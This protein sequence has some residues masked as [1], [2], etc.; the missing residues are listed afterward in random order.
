MASPLL[1]PRRSAACV[2]TVT[3]AL[4][5]GLGLTGCGDDDG[6]T[7]RQ[8]ART[9]PDDRDLPRDFPAADFPLVGDVHHAEAMTWGDGDRSVWSINSRADTSPKEA[10]DDAKATLLEAGF[11]VDGSGREHKSADY[12][13]VVMKHG[14]HHVTLSVF[15]G[16]V[17]TELT[18]LTSGPR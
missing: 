9:S 14:D 6:A 11:E 8:T 7:P 4:G 10:F 18:Y 2:L 12:W 15:S 1:R 3:L 17:A 13:H 16:S 5:P